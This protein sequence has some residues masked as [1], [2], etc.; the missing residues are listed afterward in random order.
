VGRGW[1]QDALEFITIN[2]WP[3]T[4]IRWQPGDGVDDDDADA[5][6]VEGGSGSG[7]DEGESGNGSGDGE[8]PEQQQQQRR[9][10][11]RRAGRRRKKPVRLATTVPPSH[12]FEFRRQ[13]YELVYRGNPLC[14]PPS[15]ARCDAVQDPQSGTIRLV[16]RCVQYAF[17]SSAW[18]RVRVCLRVCVRA[19]LRV[20]VCN[21]CG[22]CACG[23][24]S[25]D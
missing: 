10:Q 12:F 4:K 7:G 16:F 18:I 17:F 23:S 13:W 3:V 11:Q 5:D 24:Q 14:G 8:G 25:A 6:A 9:R 20:S 19:C 22:V 1:Q 21:A 2:D 15:M